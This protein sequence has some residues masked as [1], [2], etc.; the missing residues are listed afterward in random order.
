M[1]GLLALKVG[2]A[3]KLLF[4]YGFWHIECSCVF[5]GCY[6]SEASKILNKSFP[7]LLL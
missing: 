6:T 3:I 2:F 4:P 1:H 7:S 5:M